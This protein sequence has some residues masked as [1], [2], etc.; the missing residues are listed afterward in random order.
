MED[1]VE[2]GMLVNEM[3]KQGNL[4]FESILSGSQYNG[5]VSVTFVLAECLAR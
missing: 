1:K 3:D 2:Y 4:N 5:T